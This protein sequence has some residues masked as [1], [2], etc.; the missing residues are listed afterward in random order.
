MSI[1]SD[2]LIGGYATAGM[3]GGAL[4]ARRTLLAIGGTTGF[5]AEMGRGLSAM[6]QVGMIG[7]LM[8]AGLGVRQRAS[9]VRKY[10][11][12]TK[13]T[14]QNLPTAPVMT[15]LRQTAHGPVVN[16]RRR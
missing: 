8:G 10:G 4:A 9:I 15:W 7:G 1:A 16:V 11:I 3:V 13:A 5:H 6:T 12:P 2:A 14:K